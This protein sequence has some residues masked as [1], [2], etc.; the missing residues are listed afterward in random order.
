M[1]RYANKSAVMEEQSA[2][3]CVSTRRSVSPL[4]HFRRR[5]SNGLKKKQKISSIMSGLLGFFKCV[6]NS[7]LLRQKQVMVLGDKSSGNGEVS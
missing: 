4:L 6:S 7:F 5:V 3:A 2:R 1:N